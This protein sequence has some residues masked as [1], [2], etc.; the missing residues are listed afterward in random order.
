MCNSFHSSQ[1]RVKKFASMFPELTTERFILKQV[2][3]EDQAFLFEGLSDPVTMPYNGVYFKTFEETQAQLEWYKKNWEEGTGLNWKITSKE[4]GESIGVISVYYYKPEHKKAEIGYWLLPRF[5]QQGIAS[6]VIQPVVDYWKTEKDLH[7]L[8]AFVEEENIAS[9]K[10]MEKA[11][12]TYEGI[13]RDCEIKFG[14]YVSLR[15]YSLLLS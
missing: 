4:T 13:M 3:A 1:I 8:E 12:F 5:W 10:L 6:E 9:I 15:I 11:G 14:K 7:R 2:Q